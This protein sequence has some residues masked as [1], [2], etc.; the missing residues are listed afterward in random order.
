MT[1]VL[2]ESLPQGWQLPWVEEVKKTQTMM[3]HG[4]THLISASSIC[5]KNALRINQVGH[6]QIKE[7]SFILMTSIHPN[8]TFTP[9]PMPKRT[10]A[11]SS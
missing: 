1:R 6:L 8:K 4:L 5:F 11:A 7:L 9:I 3:E 2:V 10:A